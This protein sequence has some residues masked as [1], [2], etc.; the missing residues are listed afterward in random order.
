MILC[1]AQ[2]Q[3]ERLSNISHK[4]KLYTKL[5][6]FLSVHEVCGNQIRERLTRGYLE[7][8]LI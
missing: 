4:F 1:K 5:M 8:A 7:V 2:R 6:T 3:G